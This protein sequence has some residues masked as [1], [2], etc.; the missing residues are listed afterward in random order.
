MSPGASQSTRKQKAGSL[1][2][3]APQP[4][5]L[6]GCSFDKICEAAAQPYLNDF[7]PHP[8]SLSLHLHHTGT[9]PACTAVCLLN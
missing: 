9:M 4:S 7:G 6:S 1:S 3:P 2:K 5:A 8:H